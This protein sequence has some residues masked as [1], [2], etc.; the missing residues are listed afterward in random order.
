MKI[1]YTG[2]QDEI[3]LRHVTFTK[4][5][6]VEFDSECQADSDLA[7]K[8]LALPDFEEV[9]RGRKKNENKG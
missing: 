7:Q 6:A 1:K 8:V 2:G 9:K 5:K 4:G 3:T